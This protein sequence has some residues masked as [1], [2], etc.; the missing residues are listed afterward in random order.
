MALDLGSV[1]ATAGISAVMSAAA[2]LFVRHTIE[3]KLKHATEQAEARRAKLT[4][5]EELKAAWRW[6]AGRVL[7]HLVRH[8]QGR[9]PAN[10]DLDACFTELECIEKELKGVERS[11]AVG[12]QE[13]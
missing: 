7:Y 4:R 8:A 11:F 6:A 5:Y 2:G 12:A 9:K 13:E 1:A 10:G 3:R